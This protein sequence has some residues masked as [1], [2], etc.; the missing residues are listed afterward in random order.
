MIRRI[1]IFCHISCLSILAYSSQDDEAPTK[2]DLHSYGSLTRPKW[3]EQP[4]ATH[5]KEYCVD[6]CLSALRN[7]IS[8][9]LVDR[10]PMEIVLG[11]V[12]QLGRGRLSGIGEFRSFIGTLRRGLVE[13]KVSVDLS[14]LV[15]QRTVSFRGVSYISWISNRSDSREK[16]CLSHD[17]LLTNESRVAV[18]IDEIGVRNV[19]TFDHGTPVIPADGSPW[20]L[21]TN[22]IPG[23]VLEGITN[24][25]LYRSV[26]VNRLTQH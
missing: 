9:D 7:R 1:K 15:Y 18:S 20:Y 10:I 12:E 26:I 8:D 22:C 3:R 6:Q 4:G 25:R 11:V 14:C 5:H 21:V 24:V 2:A 13:A 16:L 23:M 17:R 19:R